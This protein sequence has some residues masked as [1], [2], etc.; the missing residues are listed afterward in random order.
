MIRIIGKVLRISFFLAVMSGDQFKGRA[1]IYSIVGC[2]HCLRAKASLREHNI[3]FVD[4]SIDQYD[5]KVRNELLEKTKVKTVPQIFFNEE[6]IGGND[7]LQKLVRS[8]LF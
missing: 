1:L 7:D 8:L 6:F 2:P 3:P 4:I 5:P